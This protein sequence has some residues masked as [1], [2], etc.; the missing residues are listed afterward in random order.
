MDLSGRY[1]YVTF[2]A[3]AGVQVAGYACDPTTGAL[4]NLPNSPFGNTGGN[5]SQGI[6]VTPGGTF[7]VIANSATNNV[8][9][10][11]L[12]GA[13]GTLTNIGPSPFAG[14]A[15]PLAAAVNPNLPFQPTRWAPEA[16]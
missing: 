10:M 11:S 1:V 12:D 5:G 4:T 16:N 7:A 9:V 13:T 2:A 6:R 3:A 8:S 15:S 14:G